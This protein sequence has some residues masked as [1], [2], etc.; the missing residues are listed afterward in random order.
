M[1]WFFSFAVCCLSVFG[2]DFPAQ[3]VAE[4]VVKDAE[5]RQKWIFARDTEFAPEIA[6]EIRSQEIENTA[7][8][9]D[10]LLQYGLPNGEEELIDNI[11]QLVLY[12]SDL[13]FQEQFLEM[14]GYA[15]DWKDAI[16]VLTDR[17]LLRQGKPQRYGTHLHHENGSLVPYPI[18]NLE[19]V[20]ELRGDLDEPPLSDYVEIMREIDRAIEQNNDGDLFKVVFN[21]ANEFHKKPSDYLYCATFAPQGVQPGED[22][23]ILAFEDPALAAAYAL[24]KTTSVCGD[25]FYVKEEGPIGQ[26]L[27]VDVQIES[28][29]DASLLAETPLYIYLVPRGNFKP[30]ES[31][32]ATFLNRLLISHERVD[33]IVE[34]KSNSVLETLILG[35]SKI[36]MQGSGTDYEYKDAEIRERVM[37]LFFFDITLEN[38]Y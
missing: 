32:S 19:I 38:T 37:R 23:G 22:G 28:V 14:V 26:H 10:L 4:M 17:V 9:K 5:V 30:H 36:R 24:C 20:D 31:Y 15:E 25:A 2:V 27:V 13:P 7:L 18:E 16:D 6:K 33:P 8:L 29:K 11:A 1:K 12:S 21:M 35:G 3:E 34:I